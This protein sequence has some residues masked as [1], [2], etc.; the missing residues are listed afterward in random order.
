MLAK[1][2]PLEAAA[3]EQGLRLAVRELDV[4][5]QVS[6]DR[7]MPQT[8]AREGRGGRARQQCRDRGRHPLKL[9]PEDEHR[10]MFEAN[11]WGRS[12]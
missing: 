7:A 12:G 2:G 10:A 11:Y 8:R 9:T 6:I 4:T 5:D 3:R 1:A